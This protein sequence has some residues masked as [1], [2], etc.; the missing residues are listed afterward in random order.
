MN[1]LYQE[2]SPNF[3]LTPYIETYWTAKGIMRQKVIHKVFPDGCVDI[4]FSFGSSSSNNRLTPF[5][6]NIIGTM[7]TYIEDYYLGE[8]D[9][10]GIRF[11][12]GGFTAFTQIPIH[13]F[14]DKT[15]N[16][17][18]IKSVFDESFHDTLSYLDTTE[19]RIQYLNS[20]FINLLGKLFQPESRITY[21]VDLIRKTHGQLPLAQV[22]QESCLSLRHFERKFKEIIGISPQAFS[23][24]IR[25]KSTLSYIKR[26]PNTSLID[27]AFIFGYYDKSHLIRE[28]KKLSGD[29]PSTFRK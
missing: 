15:I 17:S 12:P 5:S 18:L 25:F 9:M 10:V 1:M 19:K 29:I 2:H 11:S 7:T 3:R 26:N 21:A 13:E 23:N 24:I 27:S 14:T 6:P 20:Y 8:V 16:L 4:L 28:F 22:S